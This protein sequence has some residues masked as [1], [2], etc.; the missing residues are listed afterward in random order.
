MHITNLTQMSVALLR[1]S[2]VLALA[3]STLLASSTL[4]PGDLVIVKATDTVLYGYQPGSGT[5]SPIA[6]VGTFG[7]DVALGAGPDAGKG[8][9]ASY[10]PNT[11]QQVDLATGTV[12]P[13]ASGLG[14][15][16][17]AYH[18]GRLYTT[19]LDNS[20]RV[21]DPSTRTLLNTYTYPGAARFIGIRYDALNDRMVLSDYGQGAIDAMTLSGTFATLA[22]GWGGDVTYHIAIEPNGNILVSGYRTQTIQ[23]VDVHAGNS[24]STVASGPPLNE[25]VG[26]AEDEAGHIY[27]ANFGDGNLIRMNS[28]G[29]GMVN[30][31]G[32]GAPGGRLYS[33]V[34]VNPDAASRS[35]IVTTTDDTVADDGRTSLR[36][37]IANANTLS[38]PKA[39]SFNIPMTDPG[40]SGGVFTIRPLSALP[41]ITSAD[42][43]IDGTTQTAFT[44][45]SNPAGPEV[46]I[47]G[48]L[49]IATDNNADGLV[50][51]ADRGTV[52]GLVINGFIRGDNSAG[53]ANSGIEIRGAGCRVA[54]CYL[55]TDA[56]GTQAVPNW[57]GIWVAGANGNTIGGT[58]AGGGNLVSANRSVQ[59]FLV[60]ADDNV[61][62]GNFIGPDAAGMNRVGGNA[63]SGYGIDAD[64]GSLRNLIGGTEPGARNV[65]SGLSS[66]GLTLR[67]GSADNQVLG[68][69]IGVAADGVTPLSDSQ[70]VVIDYGAVRNRVGGVASGE[71]NRIAFNEWE[72]VVIANPATGNSIRGNQI[73]D[74]GKLGINLVGGTED[75]SDA[76]G[77]TANDLGDADTGPNDLQNFPTITSASVDG[78]G[79][80]LS[81]SLNSTPNST[82]ALDFYANTQADPS[83]HGE[84]E[85][86]LGSATV[87]TDGGGNAA[88]SVTLSG[89]VATGEFIA[90]T[91][92]DAGTGSTSEFSRA[93]LIATDTPAP[94]FPWTVGMDDN[95]WPVTLT[96]GG[97]NT[98][99]VQE[100][101]SI[102]SLPGSPVSTPV[103]GGADNDY[104]FAGLYTAV[105][106]SVIAA[107]GDYQP[108]GLV[109]VNEQAAERAFAFEDND[110]RYHFNL[111]NALQ[112]D[113]LLTVSFD[114]LSLQTD[115]ADPRYGVEIYFN[116]VKVQPEIVIRPAQLGMTH[117][118][119][120]FTLASVNAQVGQ[121]FDNI[122]SL[123]GINYNAA[124]GG[125]WM[126]IDYVQLSPVLPMAF[127]EFPW[128]V[129]MD[130]NDWPVTLTGGGPNTAFVQENG[131]I[132][133]LPGSPVSTP[134]PQRADND[135]YFA[136]LYTTVIP[137]VIAAY[138]DYQP[139]GLVPVNE[140]A[141]ERA[142][143]SA[144]NDLRYHFNLPNT[145]QPDDL[146]TVS[147]DALSL[148]TDQA[149]P[150]YGVEI[151]FNG[152]KVQPEIVI[153]P[154]QLGMTHS[155]PA[156]TLASVNAWVGQGF[157]N[158][159]SLRGIN[160]NTEGGGN[161]MGIDYVQL[162]PVLPTAPMPDVANLP[163]I[164]GECSATI[165]TAPSATDTRGGTIR[166]TTTDPLT[167]NAQGAYAVTWHYNDGRGNEATQTQTVI[168]KDTMAPVITLNGSATMAVECHSTFTDPGA[169]ANDACAGTFGV[170]VAGSVD[171]NTPGTYTL[172]YAASD[173][174]GNAALL[175]TRTV[176]VVDTTP[177]APTVA[178]LPPVTGQCSAT[179]TPPT[180]S[181]ACDGAIT[182]TTSDP[183]VYN[184]PGTYVVRWTFTDSHGNSSTAN[185]NVIVQDTTAPVITCPADISISCSGDQFVPVTFSA[186]VTDNC[187]RSPTL[188][189]SPAS[190]T[191]FP[192]GSTL[193]TCTATDASGNPSSCTFNVVRAALAFSGFLA[194]IGGADSTGGS[195]ASPLR[196]F[197]TGST[198]PVK[199]SADCG[200]APVLAGI[201]RLQV[202]QYTSATA[203]G[204]A[205]DAIPQESAATGNQFRLSDGQWILNLDTKATGMRQGIWF[206]RATLSDG[207]QHTVWLQLK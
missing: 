33:L 118:S 175:V 71:G 148:Q 183:L 158:I 188:T 63:L 139:V 201:H 22:S 113:D 54:G 103:P 38:G 102:N 152:V 49:A 138:G 90:A 165:P 61:V 149:D 117:F 150:R 198:V 106:P 164:T 62:Q 156:F 186:T 192:V 104:Y 127:A 97:P 109:P 116:G 124:G 6:T 83:G 122:V 45:D 181:D 123:R 79:V 196:T 99:F 193:V 160:Y 131:S 34:V 197:K 30:L 169:T 9:V 107:Y 65:I 16:G 194:P 32:I 143:A 121:G 91:A 68:N 173:P 128:T 200:G 191:G 172:T 167:Y 29:S 174:S 205:I 48:A 161:W 185:Q 85:R 93:M 129:G 52:R 176:K 96:G 179:V 67:S 154:A 47:N 53:Q 21:Y 55:G 70:G 125:N 37:A 130:D 1:L 166:G 144:D 202:V 41:A 73:F 25:P 86:Y 171:A 178:S 89:S 74:N 15:Y 168:V 69:F 57:F 111:P 142:F 2:C 60:S 100:N 134:A 12:T 141:A 3:A 56:T 189:F 42:T 182:G 13:F 36:E 207:S 10:V 155:S 77:V 8:W 87:T 46:V 31:G 112:P 11:L 105:I 119:P 81:G 18:N 51:Q 82:F 19:A 58:A 114:A 27:A 163:T 206:F 66:V 199:F 145:L 24:V 140:Q 64:S 190:G 50:L 88:F 101:G 72:G 170:S 137:S 94:V 98:A 35:L 92:T 126:G 7:N 39:I 110:L 95:D 84:G 133:S 78:S 5:V 4:N 180:A 184:S 187:D 177:P 162:S 147:F 108:V 26:V 44:G 75:T 40:Y 20:V 195:Y 135:Y 203:A 136:G 151:Y 43:L 146:L 204:N 120:S 153:R 115:Q 132:N 14:F 76:Y 157:D 80:H 23:R 17:L 159:V 59:L 28:D